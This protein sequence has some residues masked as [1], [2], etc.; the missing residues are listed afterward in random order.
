MKK[1]AILSF[2]K[3]IKQF[4]EL[5]FA[6]IALIIISFEEYVWFYV[7][8]FVKVLRKNVIFNKLGLFISGSHPYVAA[9]FFLVPII[10]LIPIKLLAVFLLAKGY[11]ITGGGLYVVIKLLSA[12]IA[13]W[14]YSY[15]KNSLIQLSWFNKSG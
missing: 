9:S 6:I 7:G 1:F 8:K 2:M 11:L 12:T 13:K 3:K 10:M 14:I 15:A 4:L 5:P